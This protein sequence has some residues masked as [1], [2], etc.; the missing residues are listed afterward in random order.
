MQLNHLNLQ[1]SDAAQCADFLSQHF[2]LQTVL[3]RPDRTLIAMRAGD[4]DLVIQQSD[5]AEAQATSYPAG[6]HFG[7]I[8]AGEQALR[9]AHAR[10][11]SAGV[12]GVGAITESRRGQQ[13]FVDGPG[14]L[15]IELGWH[16][17]KS[18]GSV[19]GA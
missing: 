4:F 7:F 6:F 10:L 8:V 1:V 19:A 15:T 3:E 12:P 9:Q 16:L 18:A 14:G 11:L 17:P 2:D 13:F 5:P